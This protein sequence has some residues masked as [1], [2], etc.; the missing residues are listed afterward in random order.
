MSLELYQEYSREEV[1]DM[2]DSCTPFTPNAGTW[3]IQ[4][5]IQIKRTHDFVF[6]VTLGTKQGCHSFTEGI[7]DSG[8]VKWQ[9]QPKNDIN[10]NLIQTLI[11]HNST[12][13]NIYL[14]YRNL[15]L[16]RYYTYLGLLDYVSHNPLSNKPVDF[17]WQ[18]LNWDPPNR[19]I[20]H[21]VLNATSCKDKKLDL[22]LKNTKRVDFDKLHAY[23][24]EIGELGERIVLQFEKENLQKLGCPDLAE[25][26][27]LTR[28]KLGNTAPFD[29]QSYTPKG[30]I[31]YIEVKTTT[32]NKNIPFFLSMRELNFARNN[33]K[34]YY[35]YRVYNLIREAKEATIEI[36]QDIETTFIL[37]TD[38][39]KAYITK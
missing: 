16:S 14:F 29:I 32:G 24:D 6:F 2:F 11:N 4:G 5:I 1:H 3:G 20:D 9:S 25:K 27:F 15:K 31:K 38:S 8:L 35:L 36:Y 22:D 21:F 12:L 23:N 37:K 33:S 26:V 18:I 7:S 34:A 13:N 10:S 19:I 39:F 28:D 17:V 30:D